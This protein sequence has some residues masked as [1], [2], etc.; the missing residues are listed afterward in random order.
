MELAPPLFV[1]QTVASWRPDVIHVRL[2]LVS[3]AQGRGYRNSCSREFAVLARIG[4][5]FGYALG[6]VQRIASIWSGRLEASERDDHGPNR[7]NFARTDAWI[8]IS[9]C[10]LRTGASRI[11]PR[12][13]A[14][15]Q[16]GRTT[17]LRTEP[18]MVDLPQCPNT[19]RD[20][21]PKRQCSRDRA[22][23]VGRFKAGSL[24]PSRQCSNNQ[25]L[26]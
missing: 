1:E 9:S 24:L 23:A 22:I 3:A 14:H 10:R 17:R 11:M 26:A 6:H 19:R 18:A 2:R 16:G 21:G 7:G 5:G 4:A 20:E 12:S 8:A 13:T 25:T 15:R